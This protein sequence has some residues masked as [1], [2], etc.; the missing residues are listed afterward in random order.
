MGTLPKKKL[1][2]EKYEFWIIDKLE[3]YDRLNLNI[4]DL[5]L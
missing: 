3:K 1:S 2:Q 5:C 4:T